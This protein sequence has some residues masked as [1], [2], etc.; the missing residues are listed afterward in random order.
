MDFNTRQKHIIIA[1]Q[2]YVT[3]DPQEPFNLGE[4][5]P[6]RRTE[7]PMTWIQEGSNFRLD[8]NLPEAS[9][10]DVYFA[11]NVA[12][13]HVIG[14]TIWENNTV[15]AVQIPGVHV[16]DTPAGL[17]FT[18]TSSGALHILT[19]GVIGQHAH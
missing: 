11:T 19:C 5:I 9:V 7:I 16:V 13:L 8:I 10:L 1:P 14:E 2:I 15:H 3:L 4:E 6:P 18:C 12:S 17:R